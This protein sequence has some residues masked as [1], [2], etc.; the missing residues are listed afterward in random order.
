MRENV[1]L[2]P[3]SQL[4]VVICNLRDI[5]Q[6]F[7]VTFSK[8]PLAILPVIIILGKHEC[9]DEVS[10]GIDYWTRVPDIKVLFLSVWRMS[11]VQQFQSVTTLRHT[12]EPHNNMIIT[13]IITAFHFKISK[14]GCRGHCLIPLIET[15]WT[16]MSNIHNFLMQLWALKFSIFKPFL[17]AAVW[18]C[19]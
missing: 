7:S 17:P 1:K 11:P 10:I 4:K 2:T 18:C 14:W 5:L 12:D 15:L 8:L 13:L 3:S 19:I 6:R 16:P 9:N